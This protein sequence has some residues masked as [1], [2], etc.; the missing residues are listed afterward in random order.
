MAKKQ[1]ERPV[2]S[3]VTAMIGKD[4]SSLVEWWKQ[5]LALVAA[6]PQETARVGALMPQLRQLARIEN[7][8][9]RVKL[10]RARIVAFAQLPEDQRRIIADA[11]KKAGDVDR[12]VVEED[13]RLVDEILPTVDPSVRA[14]YPR[15]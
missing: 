2:D 15:S 12:A 11:R 3:G 8:A 1:D 10:T 13:Q 9:E 7:R 5:R 14:A 6:V 4:E